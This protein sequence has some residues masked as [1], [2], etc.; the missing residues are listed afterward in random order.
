MKKLTSDRI[1][2][3]EAVSTPSGDQMHDPAERSG[4]A[5]PGKTG[6]NEPNDPDQDPAIIDLPDPRD[7]QAENSG[8]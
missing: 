5:D 2:F 4:R 6:Q 7:K 3:G 8:K 1:V